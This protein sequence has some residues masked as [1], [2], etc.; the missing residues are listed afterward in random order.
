ME[1]IYVLLVL[2]IITLIILFW[3]ITECSCKDRVEGMDNVEINSDI[4]NGNEGIQN[5]AS[6]YNGKRLVVDDLMVTGNLQVKGNSKVEGDSEFGQNVK[7][8]GNSAAQD[9]IQIFKNG[10]NKAPYF[11]ANKQGQFGFAGEDNNYLKLGNTRLNGHLQA[12]NGSDFRGGRH[13]FRD[14]ENVGRLRVGAAWGRPGI[15]A[16]DGNYLSIGASGGRAIIQND[17]RK[18]IINKAIYQDTPTRLYFNP[19]SS[20]SPWAVHSGNSGLVSW[21]SAPATFY[22]RLA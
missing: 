6:I 17:A 19:T 1:L 4:G 12:F 22:P 15:Y 20:S 13:Y 14:Q 18:E 5:I 3:H 16:E 7:I 10:D 11:Y 9:K 2:N 8:F 21:S